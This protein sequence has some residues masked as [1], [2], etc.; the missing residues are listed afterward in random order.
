[1]ETKIRISSRL[2]SFLLGHGFASA[3]EREA[4]NLDMASRYGLPAPSWIAYGEDG[5]KGFVL[6]A[7]IPGAMPLSQAVRRASHAVRVSAWLG[8]T[9]ARMHALGV[10]HRICSSNMCFTIPSA[11][12]LFCRLAKG[13][14][15]SSPALEE[16]LRDLGTLAWSLPDHPLV[17]RLIR[18]CLKN[19]LKSSQRLPNP[20]NRCPRRRFRG[21]FG[22]GNDRPGQAIGPTGKPDPARPASRARLDCHTTPGHG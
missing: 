1:M 9:L 5:R 21:P 12:C 3:S 18:I 16:R 17:A 14:S 10:L 8:R 6:I 19:Y 7:E 20:G 13:P 4:L 22:P 2:H 11:T 15:D